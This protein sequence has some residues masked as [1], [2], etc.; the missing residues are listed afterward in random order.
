MVFTRIENQ[1]AYMLIVDQIEQLINAGELKVGERLPSERTMSKQFGVGRS[2]IRE[3][4][5][6]LDI[7]GLL[8]VRSG[9]GTF[10]R[11]DQKIKSNEL[12]NTFSPTDLFEARLYIEPEIARLAAIKA[13][14]DD[15]K[16][17]ES[18]LNRMETLEEDDLY[19]FEE[20]DKV[21]HMLIARASHNEVY[22]SVSESLNR[23]RI[24]PLWTR[25]KLKSCQTKSHI[26]HC[27][28]EHRNV[29]Q[30][31]V[32]KDGAKAKTMQKQHIE[33]VKKQFFRE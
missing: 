25:M 20:E 2:T 31:I 14:E 26:A 29:F 4:I 12:D 1:K 19:T 22:Y 24:G 28:D 17:L 11:S 33:N 18:N 15:L 10:V 23:A 21:F 7:M 32:E 6:A 9:V 3:A 5:T 8:E 16:A 13:E 30:A 27:N